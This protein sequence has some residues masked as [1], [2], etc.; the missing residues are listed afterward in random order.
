MTA[1]VSVLSAVFAMMVAS[2]VVWWLL[3][4]PFD[5]A[6]FLEMWLC[7]AAPLV[8]MNCGLAGLLSGIVTTPRV[9][10]GIGVLFVIASLFMLMSSLSEKAAYTF[11]DNLNFGRAAF[12]WYFGTLGTPQLQINYQASPVTQADLLQTIALGLSQVAALALLVS[13]WLHRRIGN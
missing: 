10:I 6:P 9:A 7:G 1:W 3:L 5:L 8:L 2:G 13:A 12:L 11:W 4:G